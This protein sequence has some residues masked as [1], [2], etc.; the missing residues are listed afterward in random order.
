MIKHAFQL[1]AFLFLLTLPLH[2]ALANE[3]EPEVKVILNDTLTFTYTEPVRLSQVLDTA[4][5]HHT[6]D[7]YWPA[8]R[9]SMVAGAQSKQNELEQ[10]RL[11]LIG[12][13]R[14]LS[15]GWLAE[16]KRE[17]AAQALSLAQQLSNILLA[18]QPL[19]AMSIEAARLQVENPLLPFGVYHLYLPKRVPEFYVY[20]LTRSSGRQQVIPQQTLRGYLHAHQ[21]NDLLWP[22]ASKSEAYVIQGA[23]APQLQRWASHNARNDQLLPGTLVFLGFDET[24]VPVTVR[25]YKE[26][27]ALAKLNEDI[28]ELLRHWWADPSAQLMDSAVMRTAEEQVPAFN[29]WQRQD[30]TPSRSNYGGVGLMQ[31]PTARMAEEGE[32]IIGYMDM[33]EFRRY[34]ATLQVMPWLEATGFYVRM[35][36]RLYSGSPGFSGNN[37]YTDKGFDIKLRLL[38]ERDY[39]PELAVGLSDFAGTGH[40]SSEYL[41]ASKRIGAFDLSLGLGFGRLGTKDNVPNPFCEVSDSFCHRTG[42]TSDMGGTPEVGD[43]FNGPAALFGGVEYQTH[44][45]GLRIK[46]EY[47]GNDYSQDR[48]GIDINPNSPINV[49]LMFRPYKW[50]DLQLSY[51]RGEIFTFGFT[52]RTNLNTLSQLKVQPEKV[53]VTQTP[54]AQRLDEVQWR[55]MSRQIRK[56]YAYSSTDF[57]VSDDERTVTAFANP[58]RMRD[59]QEAVE[60]AAQVMAAELPPSVETFEIVEQSMFMPQVTTRIPAKDFRDQLTYQHLERSPDQVAETFQRVEAQERPSWD[61]AAWQNASPYRFK[62]SFG[63]QPFFFQDFGAPETFHFYQ[64][65]LK[66]SANHWLD[67]KTWLVADVG[68]NLANNFD[69][70]NF[71]VDAFNYLPLERVRTYSREYLSNDLWLDTVQA[72]R[73]E[74]FSDTVYGMAYAGLLERMFAGVGG[75][76]LWR[77]LDSPLAVGVDINWV[78]Q[79]DFNGAFGLRDYSAMTGFV[80]AYYQMPWLS[81]S[82]LQVGVGQFLAEDKGVALQFQRRFDNGVIVGAYAHLTNVSAEEYGEGS[83]TKGVFINIP[84]DIMTIK[85]SRQRMHIGWVPL[86][87]DGG[88]R[89]HRK[90]ELYGVTDARSPYFVR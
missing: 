44:I 81:D 33:Q 68:L 89:L 37:I 52:L 3:G 90:I 49:G 47:E 36:H 66:A 13:L 22:D 17:Q 1:V 54:R 24:L 34:S 70:F 62:P 26:Q 5:Q 67:E 56:Q 88:Q 51:E 21:T 19:A 63:F 25:S 8:A 23:A 38:E 11:D 43:W 74:R 53:A 39:W 83:F 71:K 64:L 4:L 69:K 87:R 80:T 6:E 73:F 84:L 65:G 28:A 85:P 16:G 75:E 77:P 48:A 46:L 29:N 79:R 10:T 40:F 14:E 15:T 27:Q 12:Q 42:T 82:M 18:W 78:K 60:R 76:V 59:G 58:Y 45:D 50:L 7:V 2:S 55:D 9:L 20:G 32:F 35:P 30:L 86:S 31:T 41:V 72:T 57:T 61:D